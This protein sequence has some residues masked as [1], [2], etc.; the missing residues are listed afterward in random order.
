[1]MVGNVMLSTIVLDNKFVGGVVVV[2]KYRLSKSGVVVVGR[3]ML[4]MS[5]DKKKK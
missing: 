5:G 4:S 2:G 3:H 1:M